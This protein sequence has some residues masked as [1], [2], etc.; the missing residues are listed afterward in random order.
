MKR[1]LFV[2]SLLALIFTGFS[3]LQ[4]QGSVATT[5]RPVK[6]GMPVITAYN[7]NLQ[8]AVNQGDVQMA[9]AHRTK[10][11]SFMERDIQSVEAASVASGA[12]MTAVQSQNLNRQKAI[13]AEV[14][15]LTLDN[16]AGLNAAKTKLPL[17]DEYE[18]LYNKRAPATN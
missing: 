3:N 10:M 14:K 5:V 17:L 15:A 18:T 9:D 12:K 16:A 8:N 4:A 13:L 7:N 2:L 1:T 11:V 6:S